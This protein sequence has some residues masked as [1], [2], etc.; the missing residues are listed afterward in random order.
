M[1][2]RESSLVRQDGPGRAGRL[3]RRAGHRVRRLDDFN[4][5]VHDGWS[6]CVFS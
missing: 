1:A 5:W 4:D 2:T 3:V 6:M